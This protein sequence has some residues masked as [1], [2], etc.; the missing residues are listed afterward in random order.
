M[1]ILFM[2]DSLK[3]F[4]LRVQELRRSH[5]FIS[6]TQQVTR[7]CFQIG[8]VT[9][10]LSDRFF[11]NAPHRVSQSVKNHKKAILFTCLVDS[12]ERWA[13]DIINLQIPSLR[14][15]LLLGAKEKDKR[16]IN[17][18]WHKTLVTSYSY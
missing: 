2:I 6:V 9:T 5:S 8:I 7:S 12:N 16:V 18:G 15:W 4:C 17:F 14:A 3:S 10:V 11:L 13:N 1:I